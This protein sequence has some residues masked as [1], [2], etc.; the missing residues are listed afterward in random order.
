MATKTTKWERGGEGCYVFLLP[1]KHRR[2]GY[3][4]AL[5]HETSTKLRNV[6]K[7]RQN[8]FSELVDKGYISG[9]VGKI[10]M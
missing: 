9:P 4:T 10:S 6:T 3:F 8:S 5:S 1:Q 2:A 7:A